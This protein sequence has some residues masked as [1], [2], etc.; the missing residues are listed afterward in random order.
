MNP[1]HDVVLSMHPAAKGAW[2]RA[3]EGAGDLLV[4]EVE[5]ETPPES[6]HQT[7]PPTSAHWTSAAQRIDA[8]LSALGA[9][10]Q[11]RVH[12]FASGPYALGAL[13]GSRLEQRFGRS[14][15]IAIY[16][17][18]GSVKTWENWGPH[19]RSR[20]APR[21]EPFLRE[22]VSWHASAGDVRHVVVGIHITRLLLEL[23][24]SRSLTDMGVTE[25][26]VRLDAAPL[27][28]PKSDALA[29]PSS[30]ERCVQDIGD[31][32]FEASR[33]YP[34]AQLHVFYSGPLALLIRAA[35]KLHLLPSSATL[36]ERIKPSGDFVFVPALN[37][38]DAKLLLGAA[39][40]PPTP[41]AP[42]AP[43]TL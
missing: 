17:Y 38:R 41:G 6:W 30:I 39:Y 12:V 15:D 37:L 14:R 34:G 42:T 18:N 28:G 26:I 10:P 13:L 4:A 36:Y 23:E 7:E 22:A 19:W 25:G 11:R 16:Q 8:T 40:P 21:E 5:I 29:D 1:A 9:L 3:I 32:L 20:P 33:E 27:D 24:L 43:V 2:R 35:A 31:L